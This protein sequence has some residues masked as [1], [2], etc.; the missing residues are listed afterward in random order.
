MIISPERVDPFAEGVSTIPQ[1]ALFFVGFSPYNWRK[2]FF[3]HDCA[4]VDI[5]SV[6]KVDMY[7]TVFH[8]FIDR[9]SQLFSSHIY[10]KYGCNGEP[11]QKMF[12]CEI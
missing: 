9:G 8:L 12:V 11:S 2:F 3:Y 5:L 6:M 4:A 10:L 7:V 1:L